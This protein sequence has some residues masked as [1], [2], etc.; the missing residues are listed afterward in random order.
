[1]YRTETTNYRDNLAPGTPSL[2]VVLRPTGAEPPYDVVAVTA[3]PAEGEA[4][5]EAGNDLV[6]AVPMPEE[7]ANVV[8]AFVAE[9]HV[10]RAFVK[11]KRDRANPEALG[12]RRG[13]SDE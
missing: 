2:W 8:A 4:F 10:E 12:R 9:H 13:G 1:L 6:D 5:T 3:D 11:R 7:M